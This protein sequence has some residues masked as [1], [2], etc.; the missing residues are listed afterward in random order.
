MV[1]GDAPL[2]TVFET[3]E[4]RSKGA[5]QIEGRMVERMHAEMA[6]RTVAVARAIASRA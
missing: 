6:Q 1:S 3:P 4:N 2:I 5:V